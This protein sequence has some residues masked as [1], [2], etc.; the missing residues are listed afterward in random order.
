MT[1]INR[2]MLTLLSRIKMNFAEKPNVA[3]V[4]Q[5]PVTL[6]VYDLCFNEATIQPAADWSC[7]SCLESL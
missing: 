1:R 3:A 4:E 2:P 5:I 6:T 7:I